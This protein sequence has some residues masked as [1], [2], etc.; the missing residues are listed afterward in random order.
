MSEPKLRQTKIYRNEDGPS[1]NA[2]EALHP[3]A[4]LRYVGMLNSVNLG[5]KKWGGVYFVA[6]APLAINLSQHQ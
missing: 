3:V 1:R 5:K 6:C 2:H 4:N